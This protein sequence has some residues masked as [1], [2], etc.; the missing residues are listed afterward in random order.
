[1]GSI[2]KSLAAEQDSQIFPFRFSV[3]GGDPERAR[4]K[5]QDRDGAVVCIDGGEPVVQGHSGRCA[6]R[7]EVGGLE[8]F[9]WPWWVVGLWW[10]RERSQRQ[11]EFW[12]G[13]WA[14]SSRTHSQVEYCLTELP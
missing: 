6:E 8:G 7:R 2:R 14:A 3:I 13:T 12:R 9:S 11:L 1:M 5:E 4:Q 10:L